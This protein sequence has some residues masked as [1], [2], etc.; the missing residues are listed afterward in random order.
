MI[1]NIFKRIRKKVPERTTRDKR[2][3]GRDYKRY[4]SVLSHQASP[5]SLVFICHCSELMS[6]WGTGCR[7]YPRTESHGAGHTG[8]MG[9]HESAH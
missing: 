7:A 4:S 9:G 5:I 1:N 3:G 8:G 2:K 6:L